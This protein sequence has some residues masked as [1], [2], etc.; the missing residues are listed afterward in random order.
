MEVTAVGTDGVFG[1]Q[2]SKNPHDTGLDQQCTLQMGDDWLG[3][4]QLCRLG[5]IA[6]TVMFGMLGFVLV[7]TT[8][9][10]RVARVGNWDC[11]KSIG[12]KIWKTFIDQPRT[13][14]LIR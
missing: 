2:A 11:S 6:L 13:S 3:E 4:V 14:R 10:P 8:P 7:P 9:A 12:V 1:K 5:R